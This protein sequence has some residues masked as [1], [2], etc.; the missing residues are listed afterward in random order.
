LGRVDPITKEVRPKGTNGKRN[1]Y[2][3]NDQ[4]ENLQKQ[5]EENKQAIQRANETIDSLQKK[6]GKSDKFYGQLKTLVSQY[7]QDTKSDSPTSGSPESGG[8]E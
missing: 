5:I 8:A 7:E 1:R 4:V 6:L 3:P 2:K